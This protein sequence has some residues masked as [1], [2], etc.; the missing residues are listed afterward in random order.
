MSTLALNDNRL[1]RRRA[2]MAQLEQERG[3]RRP[4]PLRFDEP[5]P[6]VP[7]P[8]DVDTIATAGIVAAGVGAFI[9]LL[10]AVLI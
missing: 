7:P 10:V 2:A 6:S 5:V 4:R 1:A 9:G 8:L 3:E